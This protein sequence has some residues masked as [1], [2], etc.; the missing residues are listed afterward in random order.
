MQKVIGSKLKT[1]KLV[2]AASPTACSIIIM[3][4]FANCTNFNQYTI[5]VNYVSVNNIFVGF[6][7]NVLRIENETLNKGMVS[8]L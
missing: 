8:L 5:T 1:L 2:F 6:F 4:F 7:S 3:Q